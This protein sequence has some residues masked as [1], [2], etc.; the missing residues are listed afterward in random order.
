SPSTRVATIL[1]TDY[2]NDHV[3]ISGT[4]TWPGVLTDPPSG[5]GTLPVTF[6]AG[7]ASFPVTFAYGLPAPTSTPTPGPSP[8]APHWFF[9]PAAYGGWANP[10]DPGLENT[11]KAIE[12]LATSG[13]AT[14]AGSVTFVLDAGSGWTF[15]C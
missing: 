6:T 5:T 9:S 10:N 8:T 15:N 2:A 13:T 14:N 7:A 12:W 1:L 11:S 3:G 4:A